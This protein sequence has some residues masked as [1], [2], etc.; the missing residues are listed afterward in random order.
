MTA[1]FDGTSPVRLHAVDF[2]GPDLGPDLGFG[3]GSLA[4]A[5]SG[6][7]GP[8]TSVAPFAEAVRPAPGLELAGLGLPGNR[9]PGVFGA[10]TPGPGTPGAGAASGPAGAEVAH[11]LRR[12]ASSSPSLSPDGLTVAY[13]SDASGVPALWLAPIRPLGHVEAEARLIDTGPAH[14]H[15]V[16]YA[17]D[18]RWI[19]LQVAP[20]GGE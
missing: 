3:A 15:E 5:G 14:V 8:G 12:P 17:P 10:G 7:P 11:W 16:S 19:A 18:G 9:V 4:S 2:P 1:P 20:G 13:V 6:S